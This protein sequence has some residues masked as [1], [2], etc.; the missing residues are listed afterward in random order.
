M[1]LP[2]TANS[3]EQTFLEK[4]TVV[5]LL[6]KYPT[7]YGT[8]WITTEYTKCVNSQPAEFIPHTH[9]ISLM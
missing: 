4:L 9:N 3:V 6:N 2:P 7:F 1:K 5:Q 8:R